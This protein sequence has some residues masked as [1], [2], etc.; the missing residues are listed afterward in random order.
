MT[1]RTPIA[2]T[3][4]RLRRVWHPDGADWK[5]ILP[6]VPFPPAQGSPSPALTPPLVKL[7]LYHR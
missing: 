6:R 2:R 4:M 3:L 1:D 5:R 7:I